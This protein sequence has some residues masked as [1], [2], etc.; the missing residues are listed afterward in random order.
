[1]CSVNPQVVDGFTGVC[2]HCVSALLLCQSCME[3]TCT[4]AWEMPCLRSSS[5]ADWGKGAAPARAPWEAPDMRA[6]A[7]SMPEGRTPSRAPS[8]A[9]C[10]PGH[11]QPGPV[12]V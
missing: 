9:H 2:I 12:R 4:Y 7:G 5:E 10:P 8:R 11:S 1:M 6:A 3:R